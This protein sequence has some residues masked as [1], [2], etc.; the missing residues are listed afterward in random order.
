M[1]FSEV[2]ESLK[3]SARLIESEFDV[4]VEQRW[5][6]NARFVTVVKADVR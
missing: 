1:R 2:A 5:K 4:V 6:E 3:G